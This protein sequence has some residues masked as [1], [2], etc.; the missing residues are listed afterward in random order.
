MDLNGGIV[1]K[2]KIYA[3]CGCVFAITGV[4][5]ISNDDLVPGILMFAAAIACG[6]R[7]HSEWKR[8]QA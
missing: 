6:L 7:G 5:V 8:E 2:S 4:A 1:A 3:V